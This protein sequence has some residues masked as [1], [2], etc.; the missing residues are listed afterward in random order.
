[1]SQLATF[2]QAHQTEIVDAITKRLAESRALRSMATAAAE[3]FTD[4]LIRATANFDLDAL[5][6]LLEEWARPGVHHRSALPGEDSLLGTL[7]AIQ[8]DFRHFIYHSD[9]SEHVMLSL[10]EDCDP[11]FNELTLYLAQI[12]SAMHFKNLQTQLDRSMYSSERL[13][14]HKS[15]FISVAAHELK[16]PLT[17]LEGYANMLKADLPANEHPGQASMLRGILGGAQRL[18]EIIEDMIDVS[19]LEL[20]SLQLVMQPVWIGRLL[21]I[22]ISD[23]QKEAKDRNV[24]IQFNADS[25][26]EK[27]LEADPERLYQVF[28]KVLENAIKYTPDGGTIRVYGRADSDMVEIMFEDTGIGLDERDRELIFEKFFSLGQVGLHSSSKTRF[29]GGGPGLGLAIARGITEAHGGRIW[30]E[31]QGFDEERLPG[32]CFHVMLPMYTPQIGRTT[33]DA[34]E[35]PEGLS[36]SPLPDSQSLTYAA[37]DVDDTSNV[38]I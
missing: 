24:N 19:S 37:D 36:D 30:A 26:P 31:S 29:K 1:M 8:R 5:H 6:S 16:T 2:I 7:L 28:Q 14:K 32:S 22:V 18:R 17:L 27:P 10:L 12:E 3:A 11:I 25:L 9:V 34:I 35:L 23:M 13:E 33:Q 21:G 4:A 38:P 20:D 15:D